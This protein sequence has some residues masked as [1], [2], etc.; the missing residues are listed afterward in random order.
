MATRARERGAVDGIERE[1]Q[2][3]RRP[4]QFTILLVALLFFLLTPSFFLNYEST[5]VLASTFLSILLMSVLYVF[6]RRREFTIA[7]ILAVPT[8]AGRWLVLFFHHSEVFTA[9]VILCWIFFLVLTDWVILLQVLTATRVTNDTIS[10]AV[11]AYL[12]FGL[13]FAFVYALVGMTFPGSFVIPAQ[14]ARPA[15]NRILYQ[16]EIGNLIYYSFVTLA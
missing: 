6:P 3:L 8:L 11:C 12:I 4:D 5:G 1:V 10:G 15:M 9:I 7:C 13:V 2:I 16:R 14:A